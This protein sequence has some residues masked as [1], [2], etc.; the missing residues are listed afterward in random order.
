MVYL[1]VL[2]SLHLVVYHCLI[3]LIRINK[4]LIKEI[5]NDIENKIK[6]WETVH[7]STVIIYRKYLHKLAYSLMVGVYFIS[8]TL[9]GT[10]CTVAL[11]YSDLFRIICTAVYILY[12]KNKKV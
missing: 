5:L 1:P 4:L 10:L 9:N 12:A 8:T 11:K 3:N 2:T 7:K 6:C